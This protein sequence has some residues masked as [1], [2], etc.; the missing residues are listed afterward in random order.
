M[1]V[2]KRIFFPIY[3]STRACSVPFG[4][5]DYIDISFALSVESQKLSNAEKLFV[6]SCATD[7]MLVI[8]SL[9]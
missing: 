7:N 6:C 9:I 8:A 3:S 4:H 5:L 1:T 2:E